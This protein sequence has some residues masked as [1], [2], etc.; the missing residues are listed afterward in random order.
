MLA[1]DLNKLEEV[2][3]IEHGVLAVRQ[4]LDQKLILVHIRVIWALVSSTYYLEA[5]H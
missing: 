3:H 2:I 5:V 4:T 1:Y